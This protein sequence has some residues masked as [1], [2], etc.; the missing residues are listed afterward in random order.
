M[1]CLC[2]AQLRFW[3]QAD[4]GHEIQPPITGR[5]DSCFWLCS[6]WSRVV[7]TLLPNLLRK[8]CR[9]LFWLIDISWISQPE[10]LL[11]VVFLVRKLHLRCRFFHTE[12]SWH[13]YWKSIENF[14]LECQ[15]RKHK[16][17]FQTQRIIGTFEKQAPGSSCLKPGWILKGNLLRSVF[18]LFV[19]FNKKAILNAILRLE[20]ADTFWFITFIY[21]KNHQSYK[22]QYL[23]YYRLQFLQTL[24]QN[25]QCKLISQK[26]ILKRNFSYS[27]YF[28]E[29]LCYFILRFQRYG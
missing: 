8:V 14:D 4:L 7:H 21:C 13:A 19:P 12:R 5:E 18:F 27:R 1:L 3:F 17:V 23:S 24:E 29:F 20:A 11:L 25:K 2:A 6:L 26:G 9:P 15:H 16:T 22:F 10:L 28:F